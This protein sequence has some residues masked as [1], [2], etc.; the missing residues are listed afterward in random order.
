[1]I[2][3]SFTI[4]EQNKSW[5][6]S[7]VETGQ[8]ASASEVIRDMIRE[9]EKRNSDDTKSEI[10]W[11]REKLEKSIASGVSQTDPDDLL[12]IFHARQ[13]EEAKKNVE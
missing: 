12:A 8:Y 3:Q 6:L 4:T 5:L 1:M 2:K 7:Q 9:R 10:E 13:A 11:L